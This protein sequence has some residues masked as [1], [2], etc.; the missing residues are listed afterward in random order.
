MVLAIPE[1]V[2]LGLGRGVASGEVT[3]VAAGGGD[4]SLAG[5]LVGWVSGGEA[6]VSLLP[7]GPLLENTVVKPLL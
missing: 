1:P 6:V 7:V 3:D 5:G 4:G 2:G